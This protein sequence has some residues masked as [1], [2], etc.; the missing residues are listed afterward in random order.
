MQYLFF[1]VREKK[2]LSNTYFDTLIIYLQVFGFFFSTL[3]STTINLVLLM[4]PNTWALPR[5]GPI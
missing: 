1:Y 5:L 2:N 3:G 4:R